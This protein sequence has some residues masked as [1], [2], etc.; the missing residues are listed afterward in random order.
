MSL[1]SRVIRSP[2]RLPRAARQPYGIRIVQVLQTVPVRQRLDPSAGV[3]VGLRDQIDADQGHRLTGFTDRGVIFDAWADTDPVRQRVQLAEEVFGHAAGCRDLQVVV[4]RERLH[5]GAE[6]SCGGA[7]REI[8]G[9]H[10]SHAQGN[11]YEDQRRAPGFTEHGAKNQSIE[12]RRRSHISCARS[13]RSRHRA[14][15]PRYR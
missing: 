14:G 15:G 12:Q 11:G 3:V 5:G 9:Q 6:R 1:I 7:A 13:V 10:H 4:T 8:D 2:V